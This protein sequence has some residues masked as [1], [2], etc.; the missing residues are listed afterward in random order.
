MA[1]IKSEYYGEE[2]AAFVR[3]KPGQ[4]VTASAQT[5]LPAYCYRKSLYFLLC[6]PGNDGKRKVQ[7][8]RLG[9]WQP[10]YSPNKR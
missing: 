9:R 7:K 6:R 8:F 10:N 1:G 5:V 3:T 4:A 2:P